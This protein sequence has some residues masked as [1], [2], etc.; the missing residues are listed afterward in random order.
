MPYGAGW[1]RSVGVAVVGRQVSVVGRA[2]RICCDGAAPSLS[3][4]GSIPIWLHPHL[5]WILS[6][7]SILCLFFLLQE[8]SVFYQRLSETRDSAR[9]E[10]EARSASAAIEV[11][12][13]RGKAKELELELEA[14]K[15]QAIA[16]RI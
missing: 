16:Y 5:A 13:A 4:Y 3:P 14:L 8:T 10:L 12:A 6:I 9:A 11:A 15:L 2:L 1:N 7:S